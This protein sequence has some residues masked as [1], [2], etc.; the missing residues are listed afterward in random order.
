VTTRHIKTNR[1]K[2]TAAQYIEPG[3]CARVTVSLDAKLLKIVDHFADNNKV[4]RSNV[5]ERALLLWYEALQ[6]ES[7]K[8][9]YSNENEDPEVSAWSK[10]TAKT[11]RYLWND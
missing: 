11:A 10:I 1:V 5:F 3:A 9:F 4:S 7:D 6:E 2:E 8:E